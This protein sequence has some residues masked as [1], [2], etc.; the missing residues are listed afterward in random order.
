MSGAG[1]A[2]VGSGRATGERAGGSADSLLAR[3]LEWLSALDASGRL[4]IDAVARVDVSGTNDVPSMVLT[5]EAAAGERWFRATDLEVTELFPA[6]DVALPLASRIGEAS[7]LSYRPGRRLVVLRAA[8]NAVEKGYRRSRFEPAARCYELVSNL[9]GTIDGL[10]L[11]RLLERREPS[12]SLLFE[13]LAGSPM[14][15]EP[16]SIDRYAAL[17]RALRV[18][19]EADPAGSDL[20]V[21]SVDDELGVLERW[22]TRAR[23]ATGA[24]LDGWSRA[25]DTAVRLAATLPAV[26]A[27]LAHR[28][29]HDGQ[30]RDRGDAVAL[31]DFDLLS[32][33]DPALDAGNLL[34]HFELSRRQLL[35]GADAETVAA[36]GRALLAGLGRDGEGG[37]RARLAFYRGTSLLRLALVYQLRPRW[38]HVAPA[39]IEEAERCL[40][41]AD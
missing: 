10:A 23:F 31:L 7:L 28:D 29:L 40:L 19:Q 41:S 39:L 12:A 35:P 36:A 30:L 26:P 38:S 25:R 18:L 21:H 11:P 3:A 2:P 13:H 8:E 5:V 1:L 16:R 22:S 33:A 4:G 24:E 37:F 15:L 32:R 6:G 17:G 34:A 20:P 14:R 9:A 27:A